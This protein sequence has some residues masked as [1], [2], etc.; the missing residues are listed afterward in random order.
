MYV[1][2]WESPDGSRPD[3]RHWSRETSLALHSKHPLTSDSS[4]QC[5]HDHGHEQ[6]SSGLRSSVATVAPTTRRC[7]HGTKR[8][9]GPAFETRRRLGPHAHQCLVPRLV[10]GRATRTCNLSVARRRLRD[11]G[12]RARRRAGV[13]PGY[14]GT[15][16]HTSATRSC[17]TILAVSTDT[18]SCRSPIPSGPCSA[19]IQTFT[20]ASW[21][22][23]RTT[24]SS[25]PGRCPRIV[26][27]TWRTDFDLRFERR[28]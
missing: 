14:S 8:G 25:G 9:D 18:S 24:A 23:W 13:G 7:S 10:G 3:Q 15:T 21:P 22:G 1:R 12:L 5:D 11:H 20:S 26:G 27:P 16:P 4:F 19:R 17:I 28:T 2:R 6:A